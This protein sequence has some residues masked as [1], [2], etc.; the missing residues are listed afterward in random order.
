MPSLSQASIVLIF[1][2]STISHSGCDDG[3]EQLGGVLQVRSTDGGRAWGDFLDVQKQLQFP[4]AP[5]NCLAPTSGQGLIMRPVDGKY[6][7]RIVFC[8]VRN[9]YQGDVPIWSDDS[10]KTYNYS[11]GA[12]HTTHTH[13]HTHTQ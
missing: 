6:G 5:L 1:T 2:K 9:A 7:G 12:D 13:T 4:K 3:I 10:G 8:A 11:T